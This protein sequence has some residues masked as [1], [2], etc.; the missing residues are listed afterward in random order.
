[1]RWKKEFHNKIIYQIT[2]HFVKSLSNFQVK[3]K[4]LQENTYAQNQQGQ[5]YVFA[6]KPG[7]L[8]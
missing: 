5:V 2:Q 3:L 6:A 1:M 8:E 7:V 4:L